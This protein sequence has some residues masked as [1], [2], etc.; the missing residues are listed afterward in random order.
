MGLDMYAHRVKKKV[1]DAPKF[2]YDY[3]ADEYT[4]DEDRDFGEFMYWRKHPNLHGWFKRLYEENGGK[5]NF[6]CVWL[7]LT[8]EDLDRLEKDIWLGS[9]PHT[10]GFLFGKSTS[11]PEEKER[12]LNF[13]KKAKKA[14]KAGYAIYYEGWW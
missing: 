11:S 9:L 10:D 1:L 4:E 13:V 2:F 3:E 7:E 5:G 6:N 8:L 14:I 12:D